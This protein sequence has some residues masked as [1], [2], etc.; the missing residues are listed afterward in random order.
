[1]ALNGSTVLKPEQITKCSEAIHNPEDARHFMRIKP[2]EGLAR[3]RF[4]DEVIAE[5]EA[6]LRLLEVNKDFYDPTIYFPREDVSAHLAIRDQDSHCPIQGD[7]L[8]FDLLN[9]DRNTITEEIA[10]CYPEPVGFA[11]EIKD[12]IAFYGRK[13]TIEEGPKGQTGETEK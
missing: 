13:V 7:A 6:A 5:S 9:E 3:V 2:I 12:H 8:Y 4:G 1:M 11:N 10:W